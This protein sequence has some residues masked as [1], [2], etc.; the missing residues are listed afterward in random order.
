M[1]RMEKRKQ[2]N[3]SNPTFVIDINNTTVFCFFFS[4]I[5]LIK[6][7]KGEYRNNI[8][9]EKRGPGLIIES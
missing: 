8:A 4:E 6:N 2:K 5:Q 3:I 9:N 1:L 7:K